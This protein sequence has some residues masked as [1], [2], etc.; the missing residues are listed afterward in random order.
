VAR[1]LLTDASPELQNHP[2]PSARPSPSRQVLGAAYP[3]VA[4]RLLTDAS[5]ELQTSL[6]SLLYKDGDRFQFERL[7][8]L[9]EQAAKVKALGT[10]RA[11]RPTA[12]GASGGPQQQR[13]LAPPVG[14]QRGLVAGGPRPMSVLPPPRSPLQ[15]LLSPDGTFVRDIVLDEVGVW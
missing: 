8:S 14:A 4:R 6:R 10:M 12:P 2:L 5:P 11:I 3:W 13:R 15:L 1:R 9:L 7:E